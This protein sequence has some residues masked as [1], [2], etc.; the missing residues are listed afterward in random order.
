VLGENIIKTKLDRLK[1]HNEHMQRVRAEILEKINQLKP[2][3]RMNLRSY[4]VMNAGLRR[5]V[6]IRGASPVRMVLSRLLLVPSCTCSYGVNFT[7]LSFPSEKDARF[8][9]LL[10]IF[11]QK[12]KKKEI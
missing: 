3:S 6:R 2:E 4:A 10:R 8:N 11:S 7:Q 9:Y 1:E 5:S 12:K